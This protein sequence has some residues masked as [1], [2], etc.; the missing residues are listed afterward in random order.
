MT[1]VLPEINEDNKEFNKI[2]PTSVIL[3]NI[4]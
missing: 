1:I 3:F 2:I 4:I